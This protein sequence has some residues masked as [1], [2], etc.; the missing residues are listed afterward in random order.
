[1]S[2]ARPIRLAVLACALATRG[3]LAPSRGIPGLKAMM[4]RALVCVRKVCGSCSWLSADDLGGVRPLL[5]SPHGIV[6]HQPHCV[7]TSGV[8]CPADSAGS[9]GSCS[10]NVG[11]AGSITWSG[12]TQMFDGACSNVNCPAD[13]TGAAGSCVCD[14]GFSGTITW[15]A[16]SQ[17]YDGACSGTCCVLVVL[18]GCV[19]ASP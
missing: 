17:S 1:M 7:T 13:S 8:A 4:A 9:A 12:E 6:V 10:C 19:L 2:L 14:A 15:Q 16:G 18:L 5:L 11:F 3:S